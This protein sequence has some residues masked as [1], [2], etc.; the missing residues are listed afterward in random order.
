MGASAE[1]CSGSGG[2]GSGG[3]EPV[4]CGSQGSAKNFYVYGK[5]TGSTHGKIFMRPLMC[6]CCM[7]RANNNDNNDN[8]DNNMKDGCLMSKFLQPGEETFVEPRG[9]A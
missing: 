8:N 2:D 5:G 1:R 7:C 6:A 4:R 9:A 3:R